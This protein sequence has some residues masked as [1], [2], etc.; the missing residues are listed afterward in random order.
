[1][2]GSVVLLLLLL[3]S[4]AAQ[5]HPFAPSY[6]LPVPFWMYAGGTVGALLLSFLAVGWLAGPA[7]A[8]RP[9]REVGDAPWARVL[10]GRRTIEALATVSVLGL[11]LCIATGLLGT[12]SAAFNLNMTLFWIVFVLGCT[13]LSGLIGNLFA[14]INPWQRIV[15]AIERAGLLRFEGRLATP[16]RVDYAPA[17]ILY[18]GFIV[19]ELFG[20]AGPRGIAWLLLAYTALNVVAAWTWG[21]RTWFARGELF[22][23]LFARVS[24]LAPLQV[25]ADRSGAARVERMAPCA[26]LEGR[27]ASSMI[28]VL[29]VLFMLSSTA[30]D[31]LHAT[32]GWRQLF[33]KDFATMLAPWIGDNIVQTYPLLSR[34]FVGWQIVAL[35]LSPLVYLALF[36]LCLAAMRRITGCVLS[37][38]ELARRFAYAFIPIALVYHAAHYATLLVTQGLM[39]VR[40]VSDPF[41]VGWNLFGTALWL[42][43]PVIPDMNWVWHAQVGLILVGHVASVVVAHREAL[44]LFGDRRGMAMRSQ[45][46]MLALMLAFTAFGLW[47]LAQPITTQP[48]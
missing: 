8:N 28:E 14:A 6:T 26:A 39:I 47:I 27:H 3:A 30:F 19:L 2:R 22:S 43:R 42:H 32:Q 33:W 11:L 34:L 15:L 36:A 18:A 16:A 17:L 5:A 23:V 35:L 38:G 21:A 20:R 45:L 9:A 13:Y 37:I 25:H 46:P 44:R 48:I 1:M 4:G 40:L 31:G 7:P 29:F 10:L 41:G 12:R 24:M